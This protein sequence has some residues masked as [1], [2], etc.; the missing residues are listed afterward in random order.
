MTNNKSISTYIKRFGKVWIQ[1]ILTANTV[2]IIGLPFISFD[3]V[4][5]D[6]SL[7]MSLLFAFSPRTCSPIASHTSLTEAHFIV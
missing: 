7:P 2:L 1:S 3:K 5:F 4:T 6:S